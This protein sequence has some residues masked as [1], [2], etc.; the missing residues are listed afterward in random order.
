VQSAASFNS[1][2]GQQFAAEFASEWIAAWNAHDLPRV[3]SL[4]TEDFEMTSPKIVQIAGE[5]TVTGCRASSRGRLLGH[6]S[7]PRPRLHFGCW[8]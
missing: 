1:S 2:Y 5:L 4:Y 7:V 6:S 3:L 8:P